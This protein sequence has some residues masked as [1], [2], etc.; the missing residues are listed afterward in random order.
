MRN[1]SPGT[2]ASTTPRRPPTAFQSDAP[3]GISPGATCPM[4]AFLAAADTPSATACENDCSSPDSD[5]VALD[6]LKRPQ[7]PVGLEPT[8]SRLPPEPAEGSG[9][10]GAWECCRAPRQRRGTHHR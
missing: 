4:P 10:A 2:I 9:L 6:S 3:V 8:E 5:S 7:R 1:P